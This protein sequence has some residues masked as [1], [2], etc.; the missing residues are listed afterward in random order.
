MDGCIIQ[1]D[2][3][4]DGRECFYLVPCPAF[5]ITAR[6]GNLIEQASDELWV[7]IKAVA[8]KAGEPAWVRLDVTTIPKEP[9]AYQAVEVVDLKIIERRKS[10]P[11]RA[12]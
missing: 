12:E 3:K 6:C 1:H 10:V 8:V 2:I 11:G 5:G 4:S 7:W 9:E